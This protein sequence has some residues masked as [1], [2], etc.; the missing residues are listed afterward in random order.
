MIKFCTVCGG[1]TAM[2]IPQDDDH[3]RSV[4]QSCGEIHYENP[5]MVVGSIPV[6]G[7]SVLLCKRNI[8]P[9]KGK[10]TLPA[11]FLEL[12]ET[13]QEGAFRET[14][15]ETRAKVEI[16]APYRMFNL[17]FVGQIYFMFLA[18][19]T[20]ASFGPTT[21]SSEV[22]LFTEK[23]IPWDEIAFKVIYETLKD[24]FADKSTSNNYPFLI[25]EIEP[26]PNWPHIG[27]GIR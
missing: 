19:M 8:E 21:E 7:D 9:R 27:S 26:P 12:N 16:L 18:K 23:E 24:F 13:V 6:F 1:G 11:G 10:W 15:E 25:K 20:E 3:K 14:F 4:C 5:N 2:E 17:V 22:R